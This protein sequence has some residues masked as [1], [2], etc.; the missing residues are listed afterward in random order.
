[1]KGLLR[2]TGMRR[3]LGMLLALVAVARG[4]M[5]GVLPPPT[6]VAAARAIHEGPHALLD[7]PQIG[8]VGAGDGGVGAGDGGVGDVEDLK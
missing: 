6:R 7:T 4:F 8:Q 1:M 5:P 2:A 3:S